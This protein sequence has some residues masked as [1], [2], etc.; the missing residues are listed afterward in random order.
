MRKKTCNICYNKK[1]CKSHFQC[2]HNKLC[3]ECFTNLKQKICPFCRSIEKE[4]PQIH[5]EPLPS[6]PMLQYT[7]TAMIDG[8]QRTEIRYLSLI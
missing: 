7:I 3:G 6:L 2:S 8:T 5:L 1:R 4:K